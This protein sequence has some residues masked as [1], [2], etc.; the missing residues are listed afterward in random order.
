M[1]LAGII[2]GILGLVV[3]ALISIAKALAIR[4]RKS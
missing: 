2:I 3:V 1:E 4:F